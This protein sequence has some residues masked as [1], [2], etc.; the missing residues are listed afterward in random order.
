M[1][2]TQPADAGRKKSAEPDLNA[3]AHHLLGAS[4]TTDGAWDK[5]EELCDDIG[6]RI[7]GSPA[8]ER[9]VDWGAERMDEDGLKVTKEEVLVP[10]WIRGTQR[11]T[12]L[13]PVEQPLRILTLGGSEP[14]PKGG[15]TAP[16]VVLDDFEQLDSV[17]VKGKIVLWDVPFTTYGP[18]VQY[19][20]R[21][22]SKAGAHG[23][24]A[25]LVRSVTP[26]SLDTPH[27]GAM[28]YADD[29]EARIPTA[30]VTVETATQIRRLTERHDTIRMSLELTPRF[31]DDAV[32]HNVVGEI[33][34]REAPDEII[35]MGCHLDSWD[36]GQ[37]AQ[38]DGA[39]CV[40]VMQAGALLAALPTAPR[41]TV[42]VV[43]FT[44]EENGLR[45]GTAYAEAHADENHIAAMEADTGA[46]TPQGL[47]VDA[48]GDDGPDEARAKAAIAKLD[49]LRGWLE[50]LEATNLTPSF[51]GADIGPLVSTGVLGF[52]L[53]QD[54][55]GYWPIHHTEADTLEK[56]DPQSLRRMVATMALTAWYLAEAPE[57]L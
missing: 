43:L 53:Q 25:S 39:G 54:T 56:V 12:L 47:R 44:N 37:G 22:A 11:A 57:P 49:V 24:V 8:L 41:R 4:L 17:D 29:D 13:D 2:V 55:T 26:S 51:S 14:T 7:S 18:T 30:A 34:G 48:R 42:R 27:T 31:E 23:A 52:G 32:S 40:A 3:V 15:L 21:G 1:L 38:D 20:T 33:V 35:V 45:G 10:R 46:G 36:V 16:V 6:H 50:P 19:R 28:R 5:L 9:A